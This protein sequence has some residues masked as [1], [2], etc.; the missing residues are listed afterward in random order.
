[1]QNFY[2]EG[3]GIL[4]I[5][6]YK[7]EYVGNIK[8]EDPKCRIKIK[9]IP[10]TSKKRA[11]LKE[12]SP[13]KH[14]SECSA[15]SKNKKQD[16]DSDDA[17]KKPEYVKKDLIPVLSLRKDLKEDGEKGEGRRSGTTNTGA[18]IIRVGRKSGNKRKYFDK[19]PK[20]ANY[21]RDRYDDLENLGII[22]EK[23]PKKLFEVIK[24]TEILKD[25]DFNRLNKELIIVFGVVEDLTNHAKGHKS[26]WFGDK[27]D[28]ETPRIFINTSL[29]DSKTNI[30]DYLKKEVLAYGRFERISDKYSPQVTIESLTDLQIIR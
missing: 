4:P 26:L 6:M 9:Y 30:D 21:M 11:Y 5:G 1:M 14:K 7:K 3:K 12:L 2:L 13:F 16:H 18:N 23:T 22:D 8:C 15:K 24:K 28:L 19:L 20:L 17:V 25:E 10:G 29:I 27:Y